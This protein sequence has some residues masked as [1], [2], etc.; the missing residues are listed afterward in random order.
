MSR[1]TVLTAG[2]LSTCPR[3][4][5]AAESLAADGHDVRAVSTSFV[6]W[7]A[8]ADVDL[9]ARLRLPWKVVDYSQATGIWLRIRSGMRFR[10]GRALAKALGPERMPTA[11]LGRAT[12]R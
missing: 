7:G 6:D 1:I 2:H 8:A 11:L 3:M 9:R 12:T 5:K 10:A 4:L